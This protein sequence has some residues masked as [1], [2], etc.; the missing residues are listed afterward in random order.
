VVDFDKLKVQDYDFYIN[1]FNLNTK[2]MDTFEKGEITTDHFR[3]A[4]AFPF[5]Y[6]PFKLKHKGREDYYI[7][8]S[9]ID[10]FNFKALLRD[11]KIQDKKPIT[12][13]V[14]FDVIGEEK[15]LHAPTN[16]YDAWV[17]SIMVPLV[18]MAK[19]DLKIFENEHKEKSSTKKNMDLMWSE[20]NS[21]RIRSTGSQ[22]C[23]GRAAISRN[24]S[25]LATT[26]AKS[27]ATT[28]RTF[29]RSSSCPAAPALT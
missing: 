6:P 8:G 12:K 4:L 11:C 16:L 23:T 27:S 29:S 26:Q 3:A 25:T 9:A 2:Q 19:D 10:T 18:A 1:A 28:I 7:E 13:L 15:L 20:L 24:C 14:V 22:S 21:I 17:Q 5:I